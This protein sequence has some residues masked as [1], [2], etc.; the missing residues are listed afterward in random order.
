MNVLMFAAEYV[1]DNGGILIGSLLMAL[2]IVAG[3]AVIAVAAVLYVKRGAK[4]AL[5]AVGKTDEK[6]TDVSEN[7]V[8]AADETEPEALP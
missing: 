4:E 8:H 2:L 1:G 6:A 3:V 7:S 5:L